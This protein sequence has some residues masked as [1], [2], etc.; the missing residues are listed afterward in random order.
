ME[1]IKHSNSLPTDRNW[2]YLSTFESFNKLV[3]EDGNNIQKLINTIFRKYQ[4]Q[5][6]IRNRGSDEKIELMVDA[7][8][9]ILEKVAI[10]IDEM[11]G[12]RKNVNEAIVIQTV[13]AQLPINGSWNR[14]N[15][16]TFS[17]NSSI[18]SEVC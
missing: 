14:I 11:N 2:S 5:G 6:N 1:A 8:D 4:I 12:I 7:N 3:N 10:N 13:S 9:T 17:V 15:S 18:N 16:A